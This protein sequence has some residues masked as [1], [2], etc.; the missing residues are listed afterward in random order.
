VNRR[1]GELF[2]LA[3]RLQTL[4]R[5]AALASTDAARPTQWQRQVLDYR[6]PGQESSARQFANQ[7]LQIA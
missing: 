6:C 7:H 3:A 5:V 4:A 2:G 1:R